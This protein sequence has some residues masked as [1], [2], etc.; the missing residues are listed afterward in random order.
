MPLSV[1]LF[2]AAVQGVTEFLPISSSAHLILARDFLVGLGFPAA[3]GTAADMLAFDVALHIGTLAAVVIYFWRDVGEMIGGLFDGVA[4]RGGPRFRL[5]VLVVV[6][7]IPIVIV[8][9]AA[10]NL[11]TDVFRA[12]EIIAWTTLLFGVLLWVS[13]RRPTVKRTTDDMTLWDALI[14]GGMQC[15]AIVPGV[16]RSGICM[17]AGRF[18]GFDRP[19]SARFALL[20]AIPTINAA[21]LLAGIDLRRAGDAQ[22][23]ADALLGGGLAFA[24]AFIAVAL[25]MRWLRRASYT[26]FVIYRIA[27]GLILLGLVYGTGWSPTV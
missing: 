9:F 2:L 26:P 21:G 20:L 22:I 8:G 4:G 17:T 3:E 25:M 23:T 13:D 16:S 5:L 11:V 12:T 18:L 14:V 15:L 27:L 10:K 19:L 6:A 7:T 24:F 1:I